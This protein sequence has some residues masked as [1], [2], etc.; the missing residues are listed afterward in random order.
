MRACFCSRSRWPCG[1]SRWSEAAWLLASRVRTPL[2]K[3]IT[4]KEDSPSVCVCLI[5]CDVGTSTKRRSRP[6]LVCCITKQKLNQLF[7]VSFRYCFFKFFLALFTTFC[8]LLVKV[9]W[10]EDEGPK[11]RALQVNLKAYVSIRWTE[12]NNLICTDLSEKGRFLSQIECNKR[13]L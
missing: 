3:W 1:L 4:L 9:T 13:P 11:C 7:P 5:V 12:K 2:R 8:K 10:K 6:D